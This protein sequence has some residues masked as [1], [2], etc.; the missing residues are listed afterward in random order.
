MGNR[1]RHELVSHMEETFIKQASASSVASLANF[2]QDFSLSISFS[3]GSIFRSRQTYWRK[4]EEDKVGLDMKFSFHQSLFYSSS[5]L[6]SEQKVKLAVFMVSWR[7]KYLKHYTSPV[8]ILGCLRL[9]LERLVS[10]YNAGFPP[11]GLPQEY[12]NE[13]ASATPWPSVTMEQKLSKRRWKCML[14]R[15]ENNRNKT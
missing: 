13:E 2:S 11:I 15:E 3:D 5:S 10:R 1:W 12:S 9:T 6:L 7:E 8:S 4:E 14:R